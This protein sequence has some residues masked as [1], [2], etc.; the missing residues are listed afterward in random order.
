LGCAGTKDVRAWLGG[1]SGGGGVAV[2]NE[3]L[4]HAGP[5]RDVPLTVI[6]VQNLGSSY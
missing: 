3:E 2:S 5:F 4:R 1:L 6:A